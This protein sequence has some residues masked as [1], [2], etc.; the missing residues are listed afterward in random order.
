V[1]ATAKRFAR[2][3]GRP[4]VD[5]EF[6]AVIGLDRGQVHIVAPDVLAQW[7]PDG[8]VAVPPFMG[9]CGIAVKSIAVLERVLQRAG[10]AFARQQRCVLVGFPGALGRGAWLFAE[11]AADLPWRT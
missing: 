2:F 9:L 4:A 11:D 6:G 10:V 8:S 3:L 5:S 7:A 1:A